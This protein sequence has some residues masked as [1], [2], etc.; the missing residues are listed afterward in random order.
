METDTIL[1]IWINLDNFG[2]V[3]VGS[4]VKTID[5]MDFSPP[6]TVYLVKL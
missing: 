4:R 1:Q 6:T 3:I 2:T 5:K